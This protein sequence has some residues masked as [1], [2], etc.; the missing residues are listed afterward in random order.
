MSPSTN[1]RSGSTA[2][3]KTLD[4]VRPTSPTS[5]YLLKCNFKN[6]HSCIKASTNKH[7]SDMKSMTNKHH[8][9]MKAMNH[10]ISDMN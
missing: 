3:N 10:H 7:H 1:T 8:Y 5:P 4:I 6:I 2:S 9:D